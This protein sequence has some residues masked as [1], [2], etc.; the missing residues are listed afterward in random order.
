MLIHYIKKGAYNTFFYALASLATRFINFLFLPF[1]LSRLTLQEFGVWDFYQTFFSYGTLLLTSCSTIS[2]IRFYILY[3]GDELKQNYCIGNALVLVFLLFIILN[4]LIIGLWIGYPLLFVTYPYV[5]ITIISTA[6]FSLFALLLSY[7]KV[8]EQLLRYL[9]IFCTQS[10]IVS[11]LTSLGV[12]YGY[13]IRS[14]FYANCFSYSVFLP[15]FFTIFLKNYSFSWHLAKIQLQ[16]SI[17]LLCYNF[18]YMGFFTIDRLII[19]YTGGYDFLG[20]YAL[21]WRFGG[22][23]QFATMALMDAWPLVLY[24]AQQEK[25]GH[26][27]ISKFITYFCGVLLTGGIAALII[28]HC[29]IIYFF[30]PHCQALIH[31]LPAFFL[32]LTFLEIARIMQSGLGLSVK[33]IYAPVL[34][35]CGV[36]LQALFIYF[37][38]DYQLNKILY[39]N[40][41]AFIL[42][43]LLNYC[44]SKAVYE[45]FIIESYRVIKMILMFCFFCYFFEHFCQ[46]RESL[47]WTL[48]LI[49]VWPVVLWGTI[50]DVFEKN[51]C[52]NFLYSTIKSLR[53]RLA[54]KTLRA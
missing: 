20:I 7:V 19:K 45:N 51:A 42:Y 17:P 47:K 2:M 46:F 9:F 14:F 53:R 11:L 16:Y 6:L 12:Y 27:F 39:C 24:N 28:T 8:K 52:K 35:V 3:Q 37:F 54:G 10:T 50:F 15:F 29:V 41:V 34:V 23:F 38:S 33:T 25:N 40:S 21:L 44:V 18:L 5:L 1:F 48:L 32:S 30:P 49:A 36:V 31:Y 22:I 4:L 26:F 43:G 13:G